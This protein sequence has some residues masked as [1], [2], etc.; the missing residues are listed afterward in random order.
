MIDE[1]IQASDEE[2]EQFNVLQNEKCV[3]VKTEKL[4]DLKNRIS[5]AL[6]DGTLQQGFEI[7]CKRIAELEKENADLKA[8]IGLNEATIQ[9]QLED[10]VKVIKENEELKKPIDSYKA[11]ES[12][13]DEIEEDAKAIA[14]ENEDLK[15]QIKGFENDFDYQNKVIDKYK[16]DLKKLRVAYIQAQ[17]ANVISGTDFETILKNILNGELKK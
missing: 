2:I 17:V 5:F 12:H 11:F 9:E 14:K 1:E 10:R 8:E 4:N 16:E 6:K 3:L 15:N 7:I 13:Y